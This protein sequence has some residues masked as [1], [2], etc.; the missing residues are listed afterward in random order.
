MSMTIASNPTRPSSPPARVDVFGVNFDQLDE[1]AL[2]AYIIEELER[3]HGGWVVTP[4]VD[5]LRQVAKDAQLANLVGRASLVVAD[6]AP[7]EWAARIARKKFAHRAPGASVFW[8]LSEAAAKAGRPVLL[9]GGREG[10]PEAAADALRAA[11]PGIVVN[12]Y[13]PEMGFEASLQAMTELYSAVQ[14][15]AGGVV[16]CGLGFPKQEKLM[17]ELGTAFPQTWFLGV[18]GSIDMAAG[19][20]GRAPEWMQRAGIEWTY[21]LAVEPKRL[22][23]RYLVDDIPFTAKLMRWAVGERWAGFPGLARNLRLQTP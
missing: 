17:A 10:A 16:F 21:R 14:R 1:P 12:T 23:R 2:V 15:S 5:I 4:N 8:S 19:I 18:G 9:L 13:W 7:V 20:V 3:S 6:G 22:A 11:Y